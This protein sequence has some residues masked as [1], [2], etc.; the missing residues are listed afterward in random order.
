MNDM[1]K[2]SLQ[3]LMSAL[4]PP[5]DK[6]GLQAYVAAAVR[7]LGGRSD[8]DL[9]R[10]LGV[11]PSSIANWKRRGAIPDEAQLWL[12]TTL[13]EKIAT[14]SRDLRQTDAIAREAVV[15]L[16]VC[17]A[18]N[19]MRVRDQ[20]VAATAQALPGLLAAAQ[21]IYEARLAHGVQHV[22]SEDVAEL[23]DAGMLSFRMGDQFRQYGYR[24]W[25]SSIE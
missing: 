21:F 20:P 13:L 15:H 18:G 4:T 23:L 11:S 17:T 2:A 3:S 16:L 5:A 14:Y 8:A 9:A 25:G 12:R 1:K 24:S 22:T 19:P 6:A 10:T 7:A